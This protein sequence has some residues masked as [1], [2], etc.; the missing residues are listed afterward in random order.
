LKK[1]LLYQN[2]VYFYIRN[3][4]NQKLKI[5]K[6]KKIY[7]KIKTKSNFRSLN[8]IWLEVESMNGKRVTCYFEDLKVDFTLSEISEFKY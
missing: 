2:I 1:V 5:K 8:G 4:N 6:M 7:A 3:Q